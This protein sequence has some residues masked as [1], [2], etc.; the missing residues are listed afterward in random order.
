MCHSRLLPQMLQYLWSPSHS[1]TLTALPPVLAAIL[2]LHWC[3]A[4]ESRKL[5]RHLFINIVVNNFLI[6]F[7][8]YEMTL[9]QVIFYDF[10]LFIDNWWWYNILTNLLLLLFFWST[11]ISTLGGTLFYLYHISLILDKNSNIEILLKLYKWVNIERTHLIFTIILLHLHPYLLCPSTSVYEKRC[12]AAFQ[13]GESILQALR[14]HLETHLYCTTAWYLNVNRVVASVFPSSRTD[15][16]GAHW[17]WIPD[18]LLS[19]VS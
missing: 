8:P 14:T 7:A 6:F 15:F 4:T 5:H 17:S 18:I 1:P 13:P 9:S 12:R 19:I 10:T 3:V 16:P 11:H 2:Q